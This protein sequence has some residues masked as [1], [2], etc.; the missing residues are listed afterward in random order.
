[1]GHRAQ[2]GK[3]DGKC[4]FVTMDGILTPTRPTDKPMHLHLKDVNK[5]GGKGTETDVNKLDIAIVFAPVKSVEMHQKAMPEAVSGNNVKNVS[6]EE[7]VV[8]RR[9]LKELTAQVIVLNHP[10]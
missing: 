2:E 1:M 4:L 10:G 6:V 8:V 9:R 7:C 3:A 5:I